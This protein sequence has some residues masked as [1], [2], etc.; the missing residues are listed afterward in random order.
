MIIKNI[1]HEEIIQTAYGYWTKISLPIL[2]RCAD[3]PKCIRPSECQWM[4]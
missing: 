4:H 2:V 3:I 1:S